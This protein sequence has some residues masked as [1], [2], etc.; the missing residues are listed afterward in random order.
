MST[1][2]TSF[3]LSHLDE[4][5]VGLPAI[6]TSVLL[7]NS[8]EVTDVKIPVRYASRGKGLPCRLALGQSNSFVEGTG[9]MGNTYFYT[10][11]LKGPDHFA[12]RVKQRVLPDTLTNLKV[13]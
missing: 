1:I 7:C 4:Q 12:N 5:W 10:E 3:T 6:R 2:H 13:L 9:D 8:Y 11:N